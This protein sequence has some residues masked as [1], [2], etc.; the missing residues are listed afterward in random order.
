M[1]YT[2]DIKDEDIKSLIDSMIRDGVYNHVKEHHP[3]I[4]SVVEREIRETLCNTT[5]DDK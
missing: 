5:V 3:D 4:L 1:K 2:I